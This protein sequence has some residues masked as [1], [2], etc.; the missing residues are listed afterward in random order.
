[1]FPVAFCL[2]LEHDAI[3]LEFDVKF[4]NGT[5]VGKTQVYIHND[6]T[7]AEY[8]KL[9]I[10]NRLDEGKPSSSTHSWP[11][12]TISS[13]LTSLAWH[14]PLLPSHSNQLPTDCASR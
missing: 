13:S 9:V 8:P 6:Y 14:V 3:Q 1:M 12:G 4:P 7:G 2:C 5:K 11:Q 10:A